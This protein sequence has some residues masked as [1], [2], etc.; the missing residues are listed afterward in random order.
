MFRAQQATAVAA[1]A[2]PSIVSVSE[3]NR[4]TRTLLEREIPLLWVAGEISNLTR[5]ASGH[6]YFSLKDE[7]AQVR[8][9][10]FRSRAQL[11][12]WQLA[13]GQQ[14][15]ARALVSLY[16]P[17]GDFQLGIEALRRAGLGRLY[18][19]F[20]RLR[21][22]L[23]AE[24][25]FA[26]E[27]KRSL[28]R[29][30]RAIA[31]VSSPQ[32]AAL[33]DVLAAFRRR[34]PHVEL[35]LYPTPV[36]G[37]GAA[38]QIAAAIG[39]AGA[40]GRCDLLLL[41]RGGGSIEDLWS[42]N[43]EIVARALAACPLPTISGVGHETD[44][45]IA[46]LVADLRAAT[47]T[48]AAEMASQDWAAATARLDELGRRLPTACGRIMDRLRQRLD[49]LARRL[50]HPTA[51]LAQHR[52]RLALLDSRLL[53]AMLRR[54]QSAEQ[55]L[56]RLQNR[57]ERAA[58]RL[59][60]H[61][62]QIDMLAHRLRRARMNQMEMAAGRLQRAAAALAHLNPEA[63]VARGYAIV[64][65]QHGVI[66]SNAGTLSIGQAV[67]L[68]LAVGHA[69]ARIENADIAPIAVEAVA[70]PHKPD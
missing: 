60:A 5:A 53:S 49:H 67:T 51:R 45:T 2:V 68:Q 38:A 64:R 8:C 28:P 29:Y 39:E 41:V 27:R 63:T 30:P 7:S 25:L 3:L 10:M 15:E 37:D 12:P 14:V 33:Q 65:D 11:V 34:A 61:R 50:I 58:P 56:L 16:E 69:G 36:Q 9:V 59:E 57:L 6:I 32:A 13:N 43:E 1:S 19:T 31:I 23:E 35:V 52:D 22:Q 17:R 18:E 62:S 44:V 54:K 55:S 66:V 70:P 42:F 48:A 24:G 47:P 4:L 26:P 40:G 20:A 21:Q 46:D